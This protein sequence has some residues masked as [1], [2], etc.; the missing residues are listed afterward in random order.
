MV[1]RNKNRKQRQPM[2]VVTVPNLIRPTYSIPVHFNTSVGML[3][4]LPS[5]LVGHPVRVTSIRCNACAIGQP[6]SSTLVIV[7]FNGT[8]GASSSIGQS[9]VSREIA[10]GSSSMEIVFR[11]NRFVQHTNGVTGQVLAN[12]V[13]SLGHVAGVVMVSVIGTF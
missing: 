2:Q 7:L 1:K 12:I 5:D 6:S 13:V 10:L 8:N 9:A 3:I 4:T 11:N